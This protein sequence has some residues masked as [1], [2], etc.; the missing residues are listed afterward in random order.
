[1]HRL[2]ASSSQARFARLKWLYQDILLPTTLLVMIA[3]ATAAT[4]LMIVEAIRP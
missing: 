2:D 4:I 3:L 1:M